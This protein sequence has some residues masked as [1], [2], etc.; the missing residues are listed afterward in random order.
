MVW[1]FLR[2]FVSYLGGVFGGLREFVGLSTV[3][4]L[5]MSNPHYLHGK[6]KSFQGDIHQY[7]GSSKKV[8]II[9][10][11]RQ[12]ITGQSVQM[13][14]PPEGSGDYE[15]TLSNHIPHS[16]PVRI[17]T[18]ENHVTRSGRTKSVVWHHF[19]KVKVDGKDKAE[20]NY[21]HK[22]LVGGFKNGTRH[23][24][25]HYKV[26]PWR[27]YGDV[28][29]K[30]L[31]VNQREDAKRTLSTYDF[32]QEASR[33]E[34]ANMIVLH[35]YLLPWQESYQHQP[36][37]NTPF[38]HTIVRTSKVVEGYIAGFD[39][40]MEKEISIRRGK[41]ELDYYLEDTILPRTSDF[42]ILSWWRLN[43][44][45]YPILQ[46]IARDV[47]AI[48]VSTIASE[49]AFSIGGNLVSPH[50]NRLHSNTIEA[51]MCSHNW[52]RADRKECCSTI[53]DDKDVDDEA[54]RLVCVVA[55]FCISVIARFLAGGSNYVDISLCGLLGSCNSNG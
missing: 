51:L 36:S 25:D 2:I 14:S 38:S 22:Q 48:P 18:K 30:L 40:F 31:V 33:N 12:S 21:C 29:Q 6:R 32:D 17:S 13:Q 54:S 52:L 15:E 37:L 26:C 4:D 27:K 5:T 47:L 16:S 8:S 28:S 55:G 35:E 23:L 3:L 19:Q 11:R 46:S 39:M 34:M 53:Y 49:S 42:D 20:C 10:P 9:S 1:L 43:G 41:A 24:H 45:T 44:S 50:R 7:S